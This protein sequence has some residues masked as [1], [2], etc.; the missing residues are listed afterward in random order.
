[1]EK[2]DVSKERKEDLAL[3]KKR[4]GE[5]QIFTKQSY[6]EGKKLYCNLKTRV[7]RASEMKSVKDKAK[8]FVTGSIYK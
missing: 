2:F 6:A 1:M 8:T 7:E 3:L 4:F 5:A